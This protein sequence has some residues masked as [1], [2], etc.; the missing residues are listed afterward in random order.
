MRRIYFI[1]MLCFWGVSLLNAQTED[2][3]K[4][5]LAFEASSNSSNNDRNVNQLLQ[6]KLKR[7]FQ[8]HQHSNFVLSSFYEMGDVKQI[9]AMETVTVQEVYYYF[10]LVNR[11]T[12]T[13][14]EWDFTI[15]G[16]G[17]TAYKAQQN[18]NRTMVKYKGELDKVLADI[19]TYIKEEQQNNCTTYVQFAQQQLETGNY[20]TALRSVYSFPDDSECADT[21][22][23]IKQSVI[24]QHLANY[25]EK[26]LYQIQIMVNSGE[27][28]QLRRAINKL[29]YISPQ[30]PCAE[31]A[32]ALSKTIG[33]QLN[34][35]THTKSYEKLNQFKT[36]LNN[37]D[38]ILL[39]LD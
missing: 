27:L 29:L 38:L 2:F 11:I 14:K 35:D 32:I 6:K 22:Q 12:K 18:A 33:E 20:I 31:E 5:P 10:K 25:C 4:L 3:F 16:K 23:E 30:A 26:E 13:E 37:K 39:L 21:I 9:E 28:Y 24:E 7:S 36:G 17:D 1:G 8:L 34:P 19:K 15:N